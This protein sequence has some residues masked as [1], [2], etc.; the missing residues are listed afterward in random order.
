MPLGQDLHQ[1][2]SSI[3]LPYKNKQVLLQYAEAHYTVPLAQNSLWL[4][5]TN[6][7]SHLSRIR[8]NQ[9]SLNWEWGK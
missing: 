6:S 7:R 1:A 9:V 2:L 3:A 5:D 4:Y 8:E